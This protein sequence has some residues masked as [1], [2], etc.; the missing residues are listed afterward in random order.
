MKNFTKLF[1]I[2][3]FSGATFGLQAQYC[4]FTVDFTNSFMAGITN[5]SL[6]STPPIDRTS[7]TTENNGFTNT[8]LTVA[9]VQG[10]AY[11]MSV[12]ANQDNLTCGNY[13]IVVY[14]DYNNDGDFEDAGEDAVSML[15]VA[16]GQATQS[17]TVPA[18]AVIGQ[19][20]MRVALKMIASC[21]HLAVSP[22]NIPV[23]GTG[24]HGE[25]EDY[26]LDIQLGT[27]V[28]RQE[29]LANSFVV[30]TDLAGNI[31]FEYT[32]NEG[33]YVSLDVYNVL[34]QQALTLVNQKQSSG[35][36]RKTISKSALNTNN[37]VFL[38]TLLVGDK[39]DTKKFAIR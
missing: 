8:G 22:C 24:W 23:D 33:E 36:Y 14:I 13:N 29:A 3:L 35:K 20:G 32:L 4:T 5:V 39:V 21:G 19:T 7:N 15:N 12:T 16:A 37:G 38:A 11:N 17:F 1:L 31:T 30:I 6:N 34:G 25:V 2:M 9:V 10:Q 18:T 28:A 27:G 26:T